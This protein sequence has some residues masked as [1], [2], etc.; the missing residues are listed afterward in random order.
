MLPRH[1]ASRAYEWSTLHGKSQKKGASVVAINQH[2][3]FL[4]EHSVVD[5][6]ACPQESWKYPST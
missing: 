1:K 6:R 3:S 4:S 5:N 2:L